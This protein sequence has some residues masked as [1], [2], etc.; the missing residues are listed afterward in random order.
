[1]LELT[2]VVSG[3]RPISE[4]ITDVDENPD[5]IPNTFNLEQNYPNPF[6]PSTK[7]SWQSPVG[8][9]Q[10]IKVYDVLGNEIATLV[11]EYKPAGM[12][13]VQFTMNNLASGVYFYRLQAGDFV[14]TKMMIL[15]K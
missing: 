8:S 6:N 4:I 10:T 14:Q 12:Y 1:M 5:A 13:N 15:I 9:H 3:D 2:C 11:D 7:I